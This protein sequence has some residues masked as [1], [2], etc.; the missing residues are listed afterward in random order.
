MNTLDIE[1]LLKIG[2]D[3][4]S[5]ADSDGLMREIVDVAMNLTNCDGGTLYV[6]EDGALGKES[7]YRP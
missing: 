6:L 2:I 7:T 4:S 1:R 5:N 3:L